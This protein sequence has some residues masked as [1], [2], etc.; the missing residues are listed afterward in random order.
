MTEV[1][2]TG[3][4]GGRRASALRRRPSD[5]LASAVMRPEIVPWQGVAQGAD[6]VYTIPE[7]F[8]KWP[9]SHSFRRISVVRG[10]IPLGSRLIVLIRPTGPRQTSA[11]A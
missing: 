6:E 1:T 4:S 3:P 5:G 2:P 8:R 11:P 7:D 9:V 10:L